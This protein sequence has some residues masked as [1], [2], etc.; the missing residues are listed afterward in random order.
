MK[1]TALLLG[2]AFFLF[3]ATVNAQTDTVPKMA[4][5][6]MVSTQSDSM[7]QQPMATNTDRWNNY[8]SSKYA[9]LPMPEPLTTEKIF[10]VI[11][12]YNLS[13]S[14]NATSPSSEVT[15]SLDPDNKGIVWIEGLP[16]GKI[17]AYLKQSPSTYLIPAQKTADDKDLAQGVLI[18]D[19]EDNM[20]NVCIGCTYNSDNPDSAFTVNE[21][22]T[23]EPAAKTKKSTAKAKTAKTWKYSGSKIIETTAAVVPK[24]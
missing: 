12:R 19:K 4:D 3:A 16:Q 8:D 9:M 13:G 20:L 23:E 10:P 24:Q 11:G 22:V 14:E 5:T 17:K 21:P 6:S 1:K 7:T 2:A 15:I 18:Y